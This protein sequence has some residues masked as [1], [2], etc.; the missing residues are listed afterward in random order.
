MTHEVA[1]PTIRT[2]GV[3]SAARRAMA[4]AVA[5]AAAGWML[6][7]L[8]A[9][10]SETVTPPSVISISRIGAGD[11]DD[12]DAAVDVGMSAAEVAR[13][14]ASTS[15]DGLTRTYELRTIT[16]EPAW[17]VARR[18]EGGRVGLGARVGRFGDPPREEKLI[19]G[20]AERLKA[21]YGVDW[22]PMTTE[23]A[24]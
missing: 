20:V 10:A 23:R 16:D 11:W 2:C 9:C 21:L 15:A 13:V 6:V 14:D 5:C 22:A 3:R 12:I 17:L 1:R 18:E 8:A 7:G 24:D 19:R 4:G